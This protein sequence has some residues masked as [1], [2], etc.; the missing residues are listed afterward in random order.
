MLVSIDGKPA[1]YIKSAGIDHPTKNAIGFEIAG[2]STEL[3]NVKVWE[4]TA[5]PEWSAH[6]DAVIGA[7]Q[8]N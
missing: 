7:L 1:A 6:R 4:A 3:K 5:S 8:K 2:K